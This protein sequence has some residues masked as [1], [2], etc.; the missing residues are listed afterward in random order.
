MWRMRWLVMQHAFGAKRNP[1]KILI[2]MPEGKKPQEKIRSR[3]R[4]ILK[5]I[6]ER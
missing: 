1:Y 6:L 5:W 3:W 4:I 2:G